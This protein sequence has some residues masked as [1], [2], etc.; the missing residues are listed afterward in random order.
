MTRVDRDL[1]GFER[2]RLKTHLERAIGLLEGFHPDAG[3]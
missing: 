2:S 3:Q 1:H